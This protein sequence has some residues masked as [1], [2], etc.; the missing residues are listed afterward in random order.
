M[1]FFL[2]V[3]FFACENNSPKQVSDTETYFFESDLESVVLRDNKYLFETTDSTVFLMADGG[4]S[5]EYARS[6]KYCMKLDSTTVYGLNFQIE[7]LKARQF[8]EAS[9]WIHKASLDGSIQIKLEGEEAVYRYRT[10]FLPGD[11]QGNDWAKHSLTFPVGPGVETMDFHVFSGKNVAYFDDVSFKLLQTTPE[12]DLPVE[13]NLHV[14]DSSD[15]LLYEYITDAV[16]YEAIPASSKK[17]VPAQII[18]DG[19]TAKVEMKLKGDWTDHLRTGKESYRVKIKG[20]LAFEGLKSF[21][22]QHPKTRNYLDEWVAH[23]MAD[24]ED[25]L[26]TTYDFINV[27]MN[28]I[29]FGVYALEEHFDKQ[30]LESRKRREGPILKLDET[31]F[32]TA[33][34]QFDNFDS[35]AVLPFFQESFVSVFKKNRTRK[36]EQLSKQFEEGRKL[37][38]LFKNGQAKIEDIFDIDQLAKFYVLTE[39]WAGQHGLRWHNR[40]FYFNPVT[41]KLEHVAY[42]ILPFYHGKNFVCYMAKKLSETPIIRENCF[43]NAIL[44]NEEFKQKYLYYL[45]QKTKPEYL[46]SVF[47]SLEEELEIKLKA[48][49]GET[50]SYVFEKEMYYKNAAYLRGWIPKLEDLWDDKIVIN[51]SVDDWV[52]PQIYKERHDKLYLKDLSINAYIKN[53]NGFYEVTAENYH[54]N[55]ITIHGYQVKTDR[56]HL[57]VLDKPIHLNGFAEEADTAVFRSLYKPRKIYFTVDNNPDLIAAKKVIPWSRPGGITARMELENGFDPKADYYQIKGSKVHFTGET[58]V[59]RL[60]YIPE[61]YDVVVEPGTQIEFKSGGGIITAG[62]FEANGNAERPIRIF[63]TDSSSNGVTVLN[64]DVAS[65]EYVSFEGLSNLNYKN[66]ELTGAVTIYETPASL[67]N[68]EILGNDSEDALNIIRSNFEIDSLVIIETLSDG[69]DADFCTGSIINSRFERTGNDCID[70]SGSEV[71]IRNIE[72]KESGDKGVSGGE[73]SELILENIRIEGAIT[74]VAAKDA[75]VLNGDNI[76]IS[77][78]EYGCAAFQKKPEYD[79]AQISLN[80]SSIDQT[81]QTVLVELGSLVV[82]NGQSYEGKEK[83]D[84]EALYA[85]FEK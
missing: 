11:Y 30:L 1:L 85:R 7:G 38:Y 68:C 69:F 34:K 66:W 14:P 79:G 39:L 54:L 15:Q 59:D 71:L 23:K 63:C 19:D 78:A 32:W 10:Y 70:F 33:I 48:I 74:G 42:D 67:K 22:F 2:T 81:E 24:R 35:I 26:S 80:N 20:D 50:E 51:T 5:D 72:I 29:N 77:N 83:L 4:Q 6:G 13:L 12:N 31:S 65:M 3:T 84:I 41:Q 17:Y 18:V 36:S 21:S 61:G 82:L 52:K 75:S 49:Q 40:R 57:V 76:Q 16:N 44:Y 27:R 53:L 43:D 62:S 46:D 28:D 9:V 45:D 55:G 73:A 47:E 56:K 60:I 8:I 25:I 58:I 37:L 64:G